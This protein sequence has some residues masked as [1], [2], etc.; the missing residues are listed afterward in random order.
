MKRIQV[1]S[2]FLSEV[3]KREREREKKGGKYICSRL[4]QIMLSSK[5]NLKTMH[6]IA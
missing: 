4:L 6:Q 5:F 1:I 2:H 3:G